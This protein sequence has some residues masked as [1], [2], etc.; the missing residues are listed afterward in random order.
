M[1]PKYFQNIKIY[2][3]NTNFYEL[4]PLSSM[5]E[6]VNKIIEYHRKSLRNIENEEPN[7]TTT[8]IGNIT[9][10]MYVFNEVE[11]ESNW[12]YFL[13][14]EITSGHSFNIQSTSFVL[15]ALIE[16]NIYA[17]IGGRGIAVIK[18]YINHTFGLDLYEKIADPENDIVYSL[19]SRGIT[20]NLS[21]QQETFRNEQKLQDA[22]TLAKIPNKLYLILRQD[23]KDTFFDFL[24]FNSNDNVYIEIS[25]SFSIKWK[26]SFEQTSMLINTIHD[27][28]KTPTTTYLSRFVRIRNKNLID[29][30]L[31]NLLFE[32]ILTDTR[33][34]VST[35][36]TTN[37]DFDFVH[38]DKL[39]PFYECDEYKVFLKGAR[40]PL[41][42]T[43]DHSTIYHATLKYL[44]D[45][46]NIMD[47]WNFR[48][49][50]SGIR[51]RGFIGNKKKTEAM[52]INHISCEV[53][54]GK[55]PYFLLDT[56]WFK[57][58]GN[59]IEIL[60]NQCSSMFKTNSINP[61]PL[62]V[63]WQTKN[64]DEGVYNLQYLNK[65]G[66][67][68]LDK[69]LGNY[70][71]LC[72]LLYET[73]DT[74]YL[75]HVKDGFD[76]KIRDLTN[77][78]SVSANRLWHDLKTDLSFVDQVFNRY[79]KSKNMISPITKEQFRSKFKKDIVYV[80]AFCS[81]NPN[82]KVIDN[83]NFFKSNIAKFSIIQS[84]R[85]MQTN[86]YPLVIAEIESIIPETN[87]NKLN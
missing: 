2:Q 19:N 75:I 42:V 58:Q 9:Y 62:T 44:Y 7:L 39:I 29:K 16:N 20:G 69:M 13:P 24:D 60:N 46:I 73:D 15:F 6:K 82:K 78:I 45:T 67:L 51:V 33:R 11:R 79:H 50:V 40:N 57:I 48:T 18:R 83:I 53:E 25:N 85:E 3:I 49:V 31:T 35:N 55:K 10:I 65:N 30:N 72:D 5:K 17:L 59:F 23:L 4:S 22:L 87:Y 32:K 61:N 70:I 56:H 54:F 27:I 36:N 1:H 66:F 81:K 43:K 38:P 26:I 80:L 63:K 8:D 28:Y 86:S 68:V 37:F 41:Y 12:K 21:S 77:Q 74:I 47:E 34:F 84:I 71:E 52:F 64:M 76:A 14:T